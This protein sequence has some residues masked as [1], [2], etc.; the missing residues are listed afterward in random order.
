MKRSTMAL[1]SMLAVLLVVPWVGGV[2]A[3]HSCPMGPEV[4][5]TIV[6]RTSEPQTG[7]AT[8]SYAGAVVATG[9]VDDFTFEGSPNIRSVMSLTITS[10]N[11]TERHFAMDLVATNWTATGLIGGGLLSELS[12]D[13]EVG[14]LNVSHVVL[15]PMEDRFGASRTFTD[16]KRGV[17]RLNPN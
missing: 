8:G 6:L 13:P 15:G 10:T 9:V 7:T 17:C 2:S 14:P 3:A 12:S 5:G 4:R 16:D 1:A 11:G